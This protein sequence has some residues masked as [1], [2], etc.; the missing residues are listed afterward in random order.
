MEA[1]NKPWT[2]SWHLFFNFCF[3]GPAGANIFINESTVKFSTKLRENLSF[4]TSMKETKQIIR[5]TKKWK[6]CRFIPFFFRHELFLL[7]GFP[8]KSVAK[9][10]NSVYIWYFQICSFSRSIE[11]ISCSTDGLPENHLSQ[12]ES[13]IFDRISSKKRNMWSQFWSC[14]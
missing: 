10:E 6:F 1:V 7:L 3:F 2:R 4:R 14:N 11:I 12:T 13:P 8:W 9:S 5:Q